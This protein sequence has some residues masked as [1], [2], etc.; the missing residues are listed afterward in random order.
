MTDTVIGYGRPGPTANVIPASSNSNLDQSTASSL[1][2]LSTLS[3]FRCRLFLTLRLLSS[4]T[5]SNCSVVLRPMILAVLRH[6]E[7]FG[8]G[9]GSP[10]YTSVVLVLVFEVVVIR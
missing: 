8:P 2:Y 7:V 1:S 5:I 4:T 6:T 3:T 9:N 10:S